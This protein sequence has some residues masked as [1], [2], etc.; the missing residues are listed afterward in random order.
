MANKWDR[1]VL[2]AIID[3]PV[4]EEWIIEQCGT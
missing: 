1:I 3:T 4:A 2:Q